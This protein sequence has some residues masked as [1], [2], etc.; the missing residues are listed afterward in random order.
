LFVGCDSGFDLWLFLKWGCFPLQSRQGSVVF[1]HRKQACHWICGRGQYGWF[2][3]VRNCCV[4]SLRGAE[5]MCRVQLLVSG[6][7]CKAL[8]HGRYMDYS[9]SGMLVV[10]LGAVGV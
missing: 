9:Q 8:F 4:C 10:V 6:G 1:T 7:G 5:G 2:G 3:P